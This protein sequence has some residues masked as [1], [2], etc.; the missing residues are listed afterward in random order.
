MLLTD[1]QTDKQTYSGENMTSL[2]EVINKAVERGLVFFGNEAGVYVFEGWT[3]G[4]VAGSPSPSGPRGLGPGA[5]ASSLY[6]S[7]PGSVRRGTSALWKG[8]L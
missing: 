3:P 7:P 4:P 2:A 6:S 5:R 8:L 1:R